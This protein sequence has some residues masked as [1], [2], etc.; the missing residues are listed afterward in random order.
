MANTVKATINGQEY[1]LVYNSSTGKYE[2]EVTAPSSSSYQHNSGHYFPVS[3]TA[4]DEAGNK[5]TISDTVGDFKNN[6][7]LYV[8]EQIKPTITGI[9]PS[10]GAYIGTSN[11]TI[12]FTV[13]D[14][15]N[16]QNS[17]FSGINPD[18]IVLTVGG[19]SV[20][21]S[22]ISKTAVTGG[23]KCSY[24]P[25][26]A[27]ADGNCTITIKVSDYDG[28]AS[29]TTSITF[30]IDT[31]PPVLNVTVPADKVAVNTPK[32][33]V[34]GTT[35]DANSSPV[36]VAIKVNGTDQGA[37]SVASDGS[38]SKEV[39]LAEGSN[40]I[41]ITST[42]KAGKSSTVTRTVTL[43]TTGPVFK[44]VEISPNPVNCGK[45][46]TISVSFVEG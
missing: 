19:A 2:A 33:T 11:P 27:I 4:T 30:K 13:L 9:S 3:I 8:K 40:T 29:D 15:S 25:A 44:T 20:S 5:T 12:E 26:S 37:V 23:Y 18:T 22:A 14:N 6:L 43:K 32:I 36:A 21:A 45:T 24:T 34:S 39:S 42:D 1:T 7:K 31:T 28:N 46:Y 41:T 17:G 10:S 38:F 16:G 35:S